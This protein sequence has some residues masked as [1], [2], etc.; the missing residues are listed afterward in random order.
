M[1]YEM[2]R[3]NW[4]SW[5]L[6][7]HS[8]LDFLAG[9]SE[10]KNPGFQSMQVL[11]SALRFCTVNLNYLILES[12]FI[13]DIVHA[14]IKIFPTLAIF[15]MRALTAREIEKENLDRSVKPFTINGKKDNKD[16]S[17]GWVQNSMF[18]HWGHCM[19]NNKLYKPSLFLNYKAERAFSLAYIAIA[20]HPSKLSSSL[21]LM[22]S[23]I[24][25][26]KNVTSLNKRKKNPLYYCMLRAST[27]SLTST[28]AILIRL[29]LSS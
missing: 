1:G 4:S 12:P 29:C 26:C 6:N 19:F 14:I 8:R 10:A 2:W 7:Y 3:Y 27:P 23:L 24:N 20:F 21:Q 16:C 18:I 5:R 13:K 25:K 17:L 22:L 15:L 9:P 11:L 28:R